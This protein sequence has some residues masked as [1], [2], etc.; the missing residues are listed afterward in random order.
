M[1]SSVL[2]LLGSG[3]WFWLISLVAVVRLLYLRYHDSLHKY[4]GPFLASFTNLW[5][6]YHSYSNR[7]G[8][9]LINLHEKYGSVVRLGPN[10]LSFGQPQAIKDIYGPGKNFGKVSS[11]FHREMYQGV[12]HID[13]LRLLI[14]QILYCRSRCQQR[15]NGL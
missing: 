11:M 1:F 15:G 8:K 7:Y 9:P 4:N 14:V 6:V 12:P 13:A 5:R 2:F 3:S 10:V